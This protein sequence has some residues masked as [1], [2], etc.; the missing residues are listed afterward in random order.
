MIKELYTNNWFNY[1]EFYSEIAK[2]GYKN[3]VEVGVWKGHSISFLA[4]E[5][6]KNNN[7]NFNLYAVDLFDETYQKGGVRT[8]YEFENIVEIYNQV[9]TEAG[10]R[11]YITDIKGFSWDMAESFNDNSLDFIFIDADHTYESVVKDLNAWYPKL[12]RGGIIS[13]HDYMNNDFGVKQAVNEL[14]PG[15]KLT[16]DKIVWFKEKK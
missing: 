10:V 5:L 13:G 11:K 14:M 12:K 2:K 16:K 4:K 8:E 6:I 7:L 9:L 3:L 1:E 15:F